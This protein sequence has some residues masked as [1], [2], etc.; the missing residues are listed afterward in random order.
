M[1]TNLSI[2]ERKLKVKKTQLAIN[3][4]LF[5]ANWF[6]SSCDQMFQLPGSSTGAPCWELHLIG[7][8]LGLAK[9]E[10]NPH[11]QVLVDVLKILS[12][13]FDFDDIAS[14]LQLKTC[15]F[16]DYLI[17][18][19]FSPLRSLSNRLSKHLCIMLLVLPV[20]RCIL[21]LAW[22]FIALKVLICLMVH[23]GS[24]FQ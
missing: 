17:C 2:Y 5:V 4:M 23:Q 20:F 10:H 24:Y 22:S 11:F 9:W 14:L 6:S 19:F 15:N 8:G 13:P 3:K 16:R 21:K 7:P 1:I 18:N 12:S